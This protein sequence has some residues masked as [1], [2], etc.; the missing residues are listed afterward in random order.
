MRILF[1]PT[2]KIPALYSDEFVREQTTLI[3]NRV[4]LFCILTVAI[5]VSAT[6]MSYLF[7]LRTFNPQEIRVWAILFCSAALIYHL[8][9]LVRTIKA[10]RF[11]SYLFILLFLFS[12]IDISFIYPLYTK[13][14][15]IMFLFALFFISFTIPWQPF[16]IV[17]ITAL[18]IF[19]YTFIF[20]HVHRY[21]SE[22]IQAGFDIPS[23]FS[24]FIFL[25]LASG[26]CF[27]I[28]KKE[29]ARDIENF[30]L[31][32]EIAIRNDQMQSE[33]ALATRVHKTL[34]PGSVNTDLLEVAVTYLPVNY[35][36]GD[37]AK[38]NSVDKDRQMF[39]I[40][41]VTGHGVSAALLVNRIHSEFQRL[42]KE[43][44]GPGMLLKELNA[45][46]LKEFGGINMY[47]SAFCCLLDFK[48]MEIVYSNYGHPT[49]YI[50]DTT[51]DDIKPLSSQAGLL[52]L[53][54]GNSK[55][56][57]GQTGFSKGDTILLFTDGVIETKD[58]QG[59]SYGEKRLENFMRQNHSLKAERFNEVL[60]AELEAFRWQE[61][62][63]DIFI[64]TIGIK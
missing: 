29:V 7:I 53:P 56:C 26:L 61:S 52:G 32:K 23:Y 55:I 12:L 18:H 6:I 19:S 50:Y 13:F 5:Y 59:R 33:L 31:L 42:A 49:Q 36:G 10:V 16:E 14:S 30:I 2:G 62:G 43:D 63:D 35:M 60:L 34:I 21:L 1:S 24:G 64:L 9:G 25:L 38:F 37:Y 39:I 11:F 57:Q 4:R 15:G 17:P 27:I 3:K 28:R 47:L 58:K 41:D 45:F 51:Q 54:L 40:C 48:Q 46:F 8:I 20:S 44:V 22:P